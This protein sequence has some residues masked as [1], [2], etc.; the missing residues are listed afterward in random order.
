MDVGGAK[1]EVL[2]RREARAPVVLAALA[3]GF[4][5]EAA[6]DLDLVPLTEGVAA[7]AALASG[8]LA[9]LD[10]AAGLLFLA[11]GFCPAEA[12]GLLLGVLTILPA[13]LNADV[14]AGIPGG[15]MEAAA[16]MLVMLCLLCVAA[17]KREKKGAR[18]SV[19]F[20]APQ[21]PNATENMVTL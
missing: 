4:E 12:V 10:A 7:A 15:G 8:F 16:V 18:K 19:F 5:G 14:L 20:Q 9:A 3:A 6:L 11:N 13:V 2:T 1:E 21:L 17:L